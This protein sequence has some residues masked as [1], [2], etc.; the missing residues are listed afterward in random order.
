MIS[1]IDIT[2]Q[3]RGKE[4]YELGVVGLEMTSVGPTRK[5]AF[6]QRLK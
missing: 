1:V 3:R 2:K 4:C 5:V 6:G